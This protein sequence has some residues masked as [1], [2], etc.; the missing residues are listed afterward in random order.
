VDQRAA[1]R[2]PGRQPR[3]WRRPIPSPPCWSPSRW[4]NRRGRQAAW[5]E[6]RACGARAHN[7]DIKSNTNSIFLINHSS[8]REVVEGGGVNCQGVMSDRSCRPQKL[9]AVRVRPKFPG[10]NFLGGGARI[11]QSAMLPYQLLNNQRFKKIPLM[12]SWVPKAHQNWKLEIAPGVGD[13]CWAIFQHPLGDFGLGRT[14]K[15]SC[16]TPQNGA[17][18]GIE[19]AVFRLQ[20]PSGDISPSSQKWCHSEIV[21]QNRHNR[22]RFWGEPYRPSTC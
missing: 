18:A 17:E 11:W 7:G 13:R 21:P 9:S 15:G 2:P 16:G 3:S 12:A 14:K 22:R 20:A 10:E 19:P 8:P 5:A 1:L 6:P 4:G